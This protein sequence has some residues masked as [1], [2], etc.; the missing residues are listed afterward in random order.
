[1]NRK[2]YR[3]SINKSQVSKYKAKRAEADGISFHSIKERDF[4]LRLKGC[5]E[6]GEIKFFLM[7]VPFRLPGAVKYLLDFMV[8]DTDGSIQYIDVKGCA[9][10]VSTLKIKQVEDIYKICITI[11]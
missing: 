1:M 10:P 7:Q 3:F 6:R 5:K 8:M 2:S 9:T 11:V 4:Y